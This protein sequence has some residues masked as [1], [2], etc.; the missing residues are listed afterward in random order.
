M[1]ADVM[2]VGNG[3]LGLS[4]AVETALRDPALRIAVVG[5]EPRP[6]SASVAAG[7]ARFPRGRGG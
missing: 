5:P 7:A 1:T 4:V 6:G 2:I 3:A